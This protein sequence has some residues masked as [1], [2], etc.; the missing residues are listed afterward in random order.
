VA[1]LAGLPA[2]VITKAYRILQNLETATVKPATG[3]AGVARPAKNNILPTENVL[4]NN[5]PA[6]FKSREGQ[7][8][9][10]PHTDKN[11][12]KALL[13][14]EREVIGEIKKMKVVNTTP[15]EALNILFRLQA[16]LAGE[17]S[18]GEGG[19]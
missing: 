1:R 10:L 14:K 5:L 9:L 15:L 19:Q 4:E 7:L 8:S 16:Q 18:P 13:K 17:N 11:K 12:S 6:F 2:E 3:T